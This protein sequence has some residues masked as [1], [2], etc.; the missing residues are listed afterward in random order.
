MLGADSSSGQKMYKINLDIFSH[1]KAR[2]FKHCSGQVKGIGS[3][4][5][6]SLLATDRT[7]VTANDNCDG[8]KHI[9]CI[10]NYEITMIQKTKTNHQQQKTYI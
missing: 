1:Q 10:K 2:K 3:Q 6:R 7:L 9:K 8:L 5:K 4:W